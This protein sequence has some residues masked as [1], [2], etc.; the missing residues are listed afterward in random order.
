MRV[1]HTG[2]AVINVTDEKGQR[3]L[4]GGQFHPVEDDET[5][6]VENDDADLF[7]PS[8]HTVEDVQAHLADAD[9]AETERVLDAERNG[10][11]RSSLVGD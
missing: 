9:E 6:P 8:E 11:N 1:R 10:K 4:A 5:E 2:G 3:L 7:D